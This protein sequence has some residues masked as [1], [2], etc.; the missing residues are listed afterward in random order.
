MSYHR[1]I[2]N[3]VKSLGMRDGVASNLIS[4]YTKSKPIF[5]YHRPLSLWR[6]H[7]LSGR[8]GSAARCFSTENLRALPLP[9]QQA[10]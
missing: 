3:G 7:S 5:F 9:L 8:G 10:L 4:L 2:F 1:L 6:I